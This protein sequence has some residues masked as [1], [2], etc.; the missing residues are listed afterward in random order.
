MNMHFF[1]R[2]TSSVVLA[3]IIAQCSAPAIMHAA[4]TNSPVT[5]QAK[6]V[7]YNEVGELYQSSFG[8]EKPKETKP[9]EKEKVDLAKFNF[10]VPRMAEHSA[11]QQLFSAF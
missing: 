7:S 1:K 8:I 6:P 10:L 11:R 3:G 4:D 9:K 5:Y 2:I